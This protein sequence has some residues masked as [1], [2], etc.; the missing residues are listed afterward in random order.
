MF[1]PQGL[2]GRLYWLAVLPFHGFIFRGMANRIAAAADV[3]A[4]EAVGSMQSTS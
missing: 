2:A 1:F 3:E 4:V